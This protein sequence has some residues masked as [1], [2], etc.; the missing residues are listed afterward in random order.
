MSVTTQDVHGHDVLA[1]V[2]AVQPPFTRESLRIAVEARFGKEARFCTCSAGGMT[3]DTL[4]AFLLERGKIVETNGVLAIDRGRICNHGDG[5]HDHDD[6]AD[7]A[8]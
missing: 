5:H 2:A 1:L 3:F 6:H 8:H 7:H 4:L